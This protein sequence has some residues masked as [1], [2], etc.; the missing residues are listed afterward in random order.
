M[1]TVSDSAKIA[2]IHYI[3]QSRPNKERADKVVGR[4]LGRLGYQLDSKN[5]DKDILAATRG[6]NVHINYSGTNV[7]N[8]RDILSDVALAVG[9]QQ[10]NPQFTARKR[11]TRQI[12]RE[13][14]DDKDYSLSGHSLGGS[15]LMNTLKESKSIRDRTNKAMTFNAGYTGLFHDSMKQI[16]KPLKKE[17]DKKVS[18]HRVKSDVVSAH[19]N[20]EVAFGQLAEYKDSDKGSDLFEKHSLETF[21]EVNL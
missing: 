11:K 10:K 13:Y 12:M 7:K 3:Y 21:K 17:L 16:E 2:D 5:S 15:I 8:P 14:G 9:L 20:K 18:H 4:K 19:M 1:P 6:D